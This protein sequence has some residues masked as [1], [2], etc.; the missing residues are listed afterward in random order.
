[1]QIYINKLIVLTLVVASLFWL[2][3]NVAAQ[4][5]KEVAAV[6]AAVAA[7]NKKVPKYTKKTKNLTELSLEGAAATYY[8]SGQKIVKINAKIYG[9]T[10]NVVAEI[11]YSDEK[12]LF[13][14]YRQ[15]KYDVPVG[16]SKASK[17]IAFEEQRIY[18]GDSQTL[19]ILVGK[20]VLKSTDARY[21]EIENSLVDLA[22]KLRT[23]Y[24]E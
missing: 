1:M 11:Y 17:M 20:V 13:I 23:A 10:Y 22:Q 21:A 14:F 16:S 2:T 5:E 15:N 18:F 6:R 8:L 9:E 19:K 7:I 24:A 4:S 12:P 3:G